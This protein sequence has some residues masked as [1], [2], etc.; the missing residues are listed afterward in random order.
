MGDPGAGFFTVN[1]GS[2]RVAP[3][4]NTPYEMSCGGGTSGSRLM[5]SNSGTV[6]WI[7]SGVGDAE[8]ASEI[9]TGETEE[10]DPQEHDTPVPS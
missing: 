3:E 10:H 5:L 9:V 6:V 1:P 7:A 4:R 8:S 2:V